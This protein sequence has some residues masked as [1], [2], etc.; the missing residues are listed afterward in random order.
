MALPAAAPAAAP[1]RL[2]LAARL[3]LLVLLLLTLAIG[4]AVLVSLR[5][6]SV[7][8]DRAVERALAASA[9][10]QGESAA[11]R[12]EEVELKVQ[13][14]AA[15]ASLVNY[16]ADSQGGVPGGADP[17]LTETASIFD[18][19]QERQEAFGFDLGIVLD[20]LGNVLARTDQ[21][22]AFA[23]SLA[24][25]AFAAA[26]IAELTP[27]S[28]YWRHGG[29]VYQAAI[30]PLDKG[31]DLVGFLII[32]R[33]LDDG[34]AQRLQRLSNA[35][36]A[37]L[38]PAGDRIAVAGSSLADGARNALEA[39]LAGDQGGLASAVR[40]GG[41]LDRLAVQLGEARYA[42]RLVPLDADGGAEVGS[43][44]QLTSLDEAE[45]GYRAI[46]RAVGMAGGAALVLALPLCLLLARTTLRPLRDMA[47]VAK[48]AAAGD[49]QH[50]I[51]LAGS[52]ELAELSR[53]FDSLLSDLRGE[54]DIESYVTHLSRL[55][56]EPGDEAALAG[57][58]G[59]PPPAQR[60]ALLL[61]AI[62]LRQRLQ[63]SAQ[64]TADA[65]L[66]LAADYVGGVEAAAQ[67]FA[68]ERLLAAGTRVLLG[69]AGEQR[70][71]NAL[72]CLRS[73][74][75]S[76]GELAAALFDGEVVAGCLP[77]TALPTVLGSA[78]LQAERLLLEAPLGWALLPKALGDTLKA[79]YG[80]ASVKVGKG[81][82]SGKA[83]YCLDR[84]ALQALPLASATPASAAG[85]D[86][87][88][89]MATRIGGAPL[90]KPSR[91]LAPGTRLGGRF[92]LIAVLGSGGMGVVYKA[93]DLELD[94]VV[95]LKMLKGDALRDREQLER[96]KSEIKL[97]RR[98]THPNVLRTFDFGEVDGLP[99]ISMEYV[100]GMTLR[101][102]LSQSERVP[103]TAALRI[104]RQLCAGLQAA[105]EVGVL[106]R[107]IK[108]E[109]LILEASGNAKLMDFGIARPIRRTTPG[110]TEAGFYVGTPA[111][112]APEQLAGQDV[113]HR[114]DI[115]ASGALMCEMF[116]GKLP[117][118]GSSTVDLYM[119]QMQGEP[120]RPRELGASIPEALEAIILRCL[121]RRREERFQSAAELG[122]ALDGLRT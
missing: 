12:L 37:F 6:G 63:P 72:G 110:N 96:L 48:E 121:A 92:R 58:V 46:Q 49:Y 99:F 81:Q 31:R 59:E 18:L 40:A 19:L 97:A 66:A 70:L 33:A 82:V 107:D 84:A 115:F 112:S 101:Y 60:R 62:D 86:S 41:M 16:I 27:I 67:E 5:Q 36:V 44:L 13:L 93:R 55:L 118:E 105:H 94:D 103:Y 29:K 80:E 22:E 26:S 98:I 21:P 43:A 8:A 9:E 71:P 15:D 47:K 35:D 113:D 120:R 122:A 1:R 75:D 24:E 14:L 50:R 85:H 91:D 10:V 68:G 106:H 111:Y 74:L 4:G 100:R 109:N 51:A 64:Q 61:L 78:A 65:A 23:E 114:A 79:T 87:V 53:A 88:G 32:A 57:G 11:Q 2:S 17:A 116:S 42:A 69:F 3:S 119:A 52:D 83:F 77:G 104:A 39:V 54:R 28:G 73:L 7:I 45:A 38:L 102:L 90:D 20:P 117:F 56:P 95:A 25:D 34:V 76:D 89:M 108:P 30:W